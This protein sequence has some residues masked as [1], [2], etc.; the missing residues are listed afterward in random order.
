MKFKI[1]HHFPCSFQQLEDAWFSDEIVDYLSERMTTVV[2]IEPI[3]IED[4]GDRLERCIRFRC[5]PIYKKVGPKKVDPR[6]MEW[7]ERSTYDRKLQR[8]TFVNTAT[9]RKIAAVLINEGEMVFDQR[10]DG[11]ER[12]IRATIKVKVPV[13]GRLAE[14]VISRTAIKVLNEEAELTNRF[15]KER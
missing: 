6:W 2:E 9:T 5:K 12:T 15:I 3:S 13:L 1:K 11:I 4:L 7:I 14:R 8:L 10:K